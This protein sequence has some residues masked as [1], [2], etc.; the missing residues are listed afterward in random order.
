[1]KAKT[2]LNRLVRLGI[3]YRPGRSTRRALGLRLACA[4]TVLFA[5]TLGLPTVWAQDQPTTFQVTSTTF[6]NGG[7]LPLSMVNNPCQYHPGGGNK[8]PELSWT[9]VPV[10]TR[11]FI[12]I[13]F[14]VTAS[15]THWAM[16]NI[17]SRSTGL[18]QNAGVT[19][20][21]DGPQ[22]L[23]GFGEPRYNGPC[24]P[25][26]NPPSHTYAFNVYALDIVLP[27]LPTNGSFPPGSDT[28][29]HAMITAA[30][31]GHILS[32]ATIEGHFP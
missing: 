16:Y 6:V 31:T 19:N 27:T 10:G 28:L 8:S 21:P 13:A 32:S 3:R 12:V 23:N 22:V 2:H 25:P 24:P 30:R 20:S 7:A 15:F 11:R 5:F 26:E 17:A 29:Y 14:D 9:N 18:P 1:M 4:A